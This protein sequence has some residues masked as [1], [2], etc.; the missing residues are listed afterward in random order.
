MVLFD[1]MRRAGTTAEPQ[2]RDAIAATKDFEGVT[3][4]TTM[5]EHRDAKKPAVILTS[6]DGQFKYVETISQSQ[7]Q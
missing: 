7:L 5:D 1:S 2:L 3:G 6:K 4:K